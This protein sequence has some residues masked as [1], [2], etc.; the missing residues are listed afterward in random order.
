MAT[1][2]T[3]QRPRWR[4]RIFGAPRDPLAPGAR[5]GIAL[6]AVFAWIGLG[7][8]G[9]SSSAYGPA[10][11]YLALGPHSPLALYLALATALTVFII[12]LA[13]NQ[14]IELF[15]TG[16]GGYRVTTSLLGP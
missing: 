3:P 14:V 9:L 12:A 2:P 8:D 5:H 6:M 1:N 11:S 13:Y 10:E 7:A 16:G 15:P 4:D